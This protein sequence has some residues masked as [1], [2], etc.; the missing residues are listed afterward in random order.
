MN[1]NNYNV[2]FLTFPLEFNLIHFFKLSTKIKLYITTRM[3]QVELSQEIS[4]KT[5]FFY[6]MNFFTMNIFKNKTKTKYIQT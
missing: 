3:Y 1:K 2:N 5:F 6:L 4:K